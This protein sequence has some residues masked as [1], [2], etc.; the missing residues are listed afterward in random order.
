[1]SLRWGSCSPGSPRDRAASPKRLQAKWCNDSCATTAALRH[2]QSTASADSRQYSH[3]KQPEREE[4]AQT[5]NAEY[6]QGPVSRQ[7]DH[8]KAASVRQVK[9]LGLTREPQVTHTFDQ[10]FSHVHNK[11]SSATED[12]CTQP[13]DMTDQADQVTPGVDDGSPDSYPGTRRRV[14][15]SP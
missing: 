9:S 11:P 8:S 1:M 3:R 4:N 12:T 15:S 14:P 6:S 13:D 7:G 2:P 10:G 5:C